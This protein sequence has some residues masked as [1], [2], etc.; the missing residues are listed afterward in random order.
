MTRFYAGIGSRETP[1][2]VLTRMTKAATWLASKGYTLRSGAAA[3]AD[4]AFEAGAGDTKEIYIPWRG[5][6]G[7]S[8]PLWR[9]PE[10][11]FTIAADHHPAWTRCSD[12]VR[13]LHARNVCQILG[14]SLDTPVDFVLAWT[15]DGGATGGTG[16]AIRIAQALDIPVFNLFHDSCVTDL[17]AHMKSL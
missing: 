11:A 5:F 14:Q 1:T 3:G 13:K 6:N 10:A 2:E 8:S 7:S 4:S 15:K 12:A 16:Q 17:I 9:I